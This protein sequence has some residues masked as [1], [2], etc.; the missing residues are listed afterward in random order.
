MFAL[1]WWGAGAQWCRLLEASTIQKW[2]C[3][4]LVTKSCPTLCDPM[5]CSLPG[6]AVHRISQARILG[7]FPSPRDL[8]NLGIEPS[9]P[10]W[11]A[12]FF[13]TEPQGN[14]PKRLLWWKRKGLSVITK[15]VTFQ[16]LNQDHSHKP[17]FQRLLGFCI[18]LCSLCLYV[19]IFY[20]RNCNFSLRA[21]M[22]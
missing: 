9:S 6:S 20:F 13:T 1:S 19:G 15:K 16:V 17:G 22:M 14:R 8:P 7:P 2:V 18:F 10:K 4:C 21:M 5:T 3:C 11:A 12:G